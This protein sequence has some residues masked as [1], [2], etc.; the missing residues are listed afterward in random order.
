MSYGD[1]FLFSPLHF[2]HAGPSL[3]G[4]NRDLL[5]LLFLPPRQLRREEGSVFGRSKEEESLQ[6]GPNELEIMQKT[7]NTVTNLLGIF[8][9]LYLFIG[10]PPP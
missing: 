2:V 3:G 9:K 6:G 1:S 8:S 7:Q 5:L 10:H 4:V